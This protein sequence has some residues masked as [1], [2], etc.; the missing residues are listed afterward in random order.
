MNTRNAWRVALLESMG[1]PVLAT[2]SEN[3]GLRRH[4]TPAENEE[5]MRL[6]R[7]TR[8]DLDAV[9]SRRP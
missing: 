2:P 3:A 6:L 9:L 5:R 1:H 8:A 4:R 7:A